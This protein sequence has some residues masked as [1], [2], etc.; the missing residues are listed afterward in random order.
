M[1][2]LVS[3]I[4]Q[5]GAIQQ[6]MDE[7]H[8]FVDRGIAAIADLTDNQEHRALEELAYYIVDREI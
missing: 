6:S 5:S 3:A 7:A 1:N 8:Q 4:R 2:R